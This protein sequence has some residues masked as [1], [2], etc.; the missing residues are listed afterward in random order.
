[1][2]DGCMQQIEYW[3]GPLCGEKG[4]VPHGQGAVAQRDEGYY[5]RNPTKPHRFDWHPIAATTKKR[6]RRPKA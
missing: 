3:G 6:P 2:G 1:M 4:Y 5:I